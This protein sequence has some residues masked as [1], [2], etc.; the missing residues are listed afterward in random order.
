[1]SSGTLPITDRQGLRQALADA[2]VPTLLMVYVQYTQDAAYLERFA[3]CIRSMFSIEPTNIPEE[4]ATDLR[5][6]LFELL[7]RADPPLERPLSREFVR[8]MM[9]VSV[10]EEVAAEQVPVL[11]DQMAFE[12]P[13]PRR[14]LPNRKQ[15]SADFKVA[16]IGA[17][18][19]GIAAGVKLDEAGYNFTIIEKNADFG[20][21]W[22]ENVYPGVAVDTPSHFYSYSFE[23]NPDWSSYYPK[24]AE[25]EQYLLGVAKKYG[26]RDK[27]LFNNRVLGC[28]WD[29]AKQLWR[30]TTSSGGREQVLEFNAIING[31][32][33]LNRWSMPDIP[34]LKDFRGPAMHSAGWDPAVDLRGKR[35]A[36]I[37]TG[38]SGA[39]LGTAT[40][41]LA[42]HLTVFERSKHWVMHN[43]ELRHDVTEGIRFALREIPHFK[44]WFR[45]RVYWFSGDGLYGNVL[46]DP[47]WPHKDVSISA[48]NHGAREYALAYLRERFADRPD[49]LEKM[50]PDYPIFGKRIVLDSEGGWLDTLK[51]PNVTLETRGIEHI[52]A[53]AIVLKDGTRVEVD[54][55]ALATGFEVSPALGKLHVHGRGGKDL[56]ETW[57]KDE[58]RSYLGIMVPEYPN[59]F[60]TL[61]P[62]SAPNHAAGVNMVIEAQL[63]YIIEALDMLVAAGARAIEPTVAAYEDWNRRVEEQMKHMVWTHPQ[64]RS[65][66]LAS[67]GRNWVSSPFRLAD[68][69]AMTRAPDPAAMRLS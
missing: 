44:E 34:G 11:Y 65:Y 30:I 1:M 57:G 19:G 35:V 21:T 36:L 43:P 4:L 6:R 63:Q 62:N 10:G 14:E 25:I 20:G 31:H 66:Y 26:L 22:L 15:P 46:G 53:D 27:V 68:Y 40:A 39:Q 51:R 52:E 12:K 49:L 59:L 64:A 5:E 28:A 67:T 13:V 23:Q 8:R 17:G 2:N 69:W 16:V 61:G 29:E 38:A 47:D 42:A 54:V 7:T 33:V 55:I 56:A 45:F 3:P 58:A 32:G 37:G 48:Q 9:S 60:L 50:T 24:G 18:M 41:P